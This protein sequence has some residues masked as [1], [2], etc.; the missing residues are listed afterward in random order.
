MYFPNTYLAGNNNIIT[1][2]SEVT[3]TINSMHVFGFSEYS[4]SSG[5]SEDDCA[6]NELSS[7]S[8]DQN[9]LAMLQKGTY[10]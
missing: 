7:S 6:A 3:S 1:F 8:N 2:S 5:N 9:K 10:L 4:S